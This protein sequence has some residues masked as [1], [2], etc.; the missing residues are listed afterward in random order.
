MRRSQST[1]R[2]RS[3]TPI[4][5]AKFTSSSFTGLLLEHDIR[6]SRDGKGGWRDN[7]FIEG[8][9][10]SIEYEQVYLHAYETES[11]A[12]EGIGRYI[13]FYNTPNSSHQA[14]TSDVV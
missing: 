10:R 5:A 4:R 6:I 3:S 8:L 14:R 12:R 1:A 7:V 2:P 9:W 11:A 13:N